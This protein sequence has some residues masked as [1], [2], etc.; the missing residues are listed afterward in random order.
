MNEH[1]AKTS[2]AITPGLSKVMT[3][4]SHVTS[5]INVASSRAKL[6]QI[7]YNIIGS[8]FESEWQ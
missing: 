6:V 2:V 7:A 4:D 1:Q 8:V 5:H 3:S